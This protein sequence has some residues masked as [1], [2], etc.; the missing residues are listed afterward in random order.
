MDLFHYTNLEK[1]EGIL[2]SKKIW[3]TPVQTMNDG[4]E[5]DHLYNVIFPKVKE[6]IITET[7]PHLLN[8][9]ESAFNLL[10]SNIKL[11]TEIMPYCACFSEDGDLL[12]QWCRYADDGSGVSIGFDSNY[13]KIK[14]EPPHPNT[15]I[16][17]SIGIGAIIYDYNL[18]TLILF[19]IL[20]QNLSRETPNPLN[21]ITILGNLTRYSAIFKNQSFYTEREK[22]IIYYFYDQHTSQFD[23]NFLSGPYNY[24]YKGVGYCRFELNWLNASS[25]HAIT[26]IFLGPK[27]KQRSFEILKKLEKFGVQIKESQIIKSES[28]YR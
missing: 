21:L 12:S 20:K 3:L 24:G 15:N 8:I 22:R 28:S 23:E 5:V 19:N 2:N 17:E 1:F 26:K 11:H 6:K 25:D 10:E 7:L 9:T 4:T 18:Q 27:C 16:K 13:F 14:N